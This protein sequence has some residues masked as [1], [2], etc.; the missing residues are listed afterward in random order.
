VAA[1]VLLFVWDRPT[2]HQQS[3]P[4]ARGPRPQ[5]SQVV[6]GEAS[7]EIAVGDSSLLVAPHSRLFL[8]ETE[9]SGVLVML[10]RGAVDCTV[11]PRRERGPFTVQAG[12]V[13][14]DVYGTRFAVARRG[15]SATVQ[16]TSG[17][18]RV[19]SRGTVTRLHAG[20]SWPLE[21][22]AAGPLHRPRSVTPAAAPAERLPRPRPRRDHAAHDSAPASRHADENP[23]AVAPD[24]RERFRT[25]TRL[26]ASDPDAAIA[27]YRQLLREGGPWAANALFAQGR[28]ELDRG[29]TTS[30]RRLLTTYLERYPDGANAD[31]ARALLEHLA[32]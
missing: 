17:E 23:R 3:G 4:E 13:R 11:A 10:E 24:P 20:G 25:A 1:A 5:P 7:S 29:R 30:A 2:A 21:A 28:L 22:V 6:T 31:D 8:T 12:D 9:G 27:I 18:V 32:R 15:D 26:E 14:V 19:S 16:V